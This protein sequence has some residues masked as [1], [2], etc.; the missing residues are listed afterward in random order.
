MSNDR[1]LE[2]IL[3]R[4]RVNAEAADADSK[5]LK[6][7]QAK[8]RELKQKVAAAWVPLRAHLA[9]YVK[10]LNEKMNDNGVQLVVE[11]EPLERPVQTIVDRVLVRFPQGGGIQQSI[12]KLRME[13]LSD[14][15]ISVNIGTKN[16][17]SKKSYSLDVFG[18]SSSE[19][20]TAVLEFLD[21]NT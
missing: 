16:H 5:R 11:S 9:A 8:T 19:I 14:G 12:R 2:E 3:A 18:I 4:Q 21:N 7:A 1:K 17:S 20:E 13:V 15:H 10:N 6:E